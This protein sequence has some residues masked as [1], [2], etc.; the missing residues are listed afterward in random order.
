MRAAEKDVVGTAGQQEEGR[1]GQECCCLEGLFSLVSLHKSMKS[2]SEPNT[3]VSEPRF[4]PKYIRYESMS[5]F[6]EIVVKENGGVPLQCPMLTSTN[7]TTWAIRVEAIM[8]AQG[9]WE[10]IEPEAGVAVDE[11]KNK[12]ARAFLFQAIPEDILLQVAKKKTAKEVWESLKTRYLGADR[13]QKARLHTLKSEFEALRMKDGESIDDF[14]GKLSGMSSKYNSLGATL[15]DS[16]LVRKLLDSVPD[17]YL[18]LVASIEQY[19]DIDAMPFDEAIGRLK[20]YEDRLRLRNGT[21]DGE[22]NLLLAKTEEVLLFLGMDKVG[23]QHI[24]TEEVGVVVEEDGAHGV[25]EVVVILEDEVGE[26]ITRKGET[27]AT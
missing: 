19:S 21:T 10:S 26:T 11:K 3:V 2:V 6:N 18:Q 9:V 5:A 14:A 25:E 23:V 27:R 12:I 7:Y 8:D 17:K 4:M 22:S 16:L 24:L 20:A 1:I 13:V 15:D